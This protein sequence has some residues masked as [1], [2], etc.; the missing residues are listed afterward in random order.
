[1]VLKMGDELYYGSDAIHA[2]ALIG[3]RS[4]FFNRFNYWMFK[5]RMRSRMLYPVLRFFRNFLLKLLRRT[6]INN[7]KLENND[8]F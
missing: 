8:K 4:G 3:S 6:K 7:L 1:M 2:L 5:S